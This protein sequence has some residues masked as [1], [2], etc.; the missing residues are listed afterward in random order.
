MNT[1]SAQEKLAARIAA[2]FNL[3]IGLDTDI[4]KCPEHIQNFYDSSSSGGHNNSDLAIAEFNHRIIEATGHLAC[5]FKPN[6]AFYASKGSL[7]I[8]SAKLTIEYIKKYFPEVLIIA[9]AKLGDIGNTNEHWAE[10]IFD[11]LGADAV[12][13]SPFMGWKGMK[14]FLDRK[15]KLNYILCCTS[16]E[17]A[18]EFQDLFIPDT[19]ITGAYKQTGNH[20]YEIIAKNVANPEKWNY[21][22][23][24]AL[25]TGA[26]VPKKISIVR[27]SAPGL[28]LLIPGVGTQQGD[29]QASVDS[30]GGN[31][32]IVNVS[33][34]ILYASSGT[35][36][37]V[38]AQEKAQFWYNQISNCL[39]KGPV[40][41][42]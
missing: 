42:C 12:T 32:F 19:E 40:N 11:Y 4:S 2:G 37:D 10:F 26:T 13:L 20:L 36:F 34:D 5:A 15:D 23:N 25:V 7:G 24:C 18:D 39:H 14:P 28:N 31:N 6:I 1:K 9:D 22:N 38:K 33:R 41:N 16:N 3:C 35:D 29:L 8:K 21:N 17:G 30:A 27:N